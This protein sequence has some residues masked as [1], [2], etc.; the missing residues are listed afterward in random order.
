MHRTVT[1]FVVTLTALALAS[2]PAHAQRPAPPKPT[3]VP[4]H[5]TGARGAQVWADSVLATLS[6][7]ERAAQMVWPNLFGDYVSADSPQWQRLSSYVANDKVGGMLIS[8][9][10]P[11]EMAV[12]LNALQRLSAVPLLV[13]ADLETGAGMRARG[14]YFRPNS[15]DLGGATVVPAEMAYGAANDT[16]LTYTEG[17]ITAIEGRALGIHID[18]APVMDVN[19]NPSNPVIN[20]RSYGEDPREV[21]RLGA[22]FIR[23]LQEHGMI[24]TAKHFPGHG[25]T[26]T[27]S[28]LALPIVNVSGRGSILSSSSLSGRRSRLVSA[29]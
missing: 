22:A 25:D 8:I 1:A 3:P 11:I 12:K 18:F 27:N 21:A 7:R 24:A 13:G 9:G 10:S 20:T 26:E 15:I 5:V 29:R 6:L 4:Q 17:R 23:G 2:T 16:S 19:N 14:G 28:H